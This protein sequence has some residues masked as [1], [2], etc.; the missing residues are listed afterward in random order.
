MTAAFHHYG[1]SP[2][3]LAL[4]RSRRERPR[5]TAAEQRDE[6]AAS[7]MSGKEHCEG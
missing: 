1:Y 5:H 7:C 4:L 2:Y 3:P 6:R